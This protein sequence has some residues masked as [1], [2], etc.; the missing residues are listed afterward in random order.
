MLYESY[1]RT[2][3]LNPPE[4]FLVT[5]IKQYDVPKEKFEEA[6]QKTAERLLAEGRD[7]TQEEY[8]LPNAD[9]IYT[10][11][12]EIIDAFYRRENPVTPDWLKD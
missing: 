4:M 10:F 12:N 5:L 2:D 6:I 7:L 3:R 11:D 9:I 1:N 8:E